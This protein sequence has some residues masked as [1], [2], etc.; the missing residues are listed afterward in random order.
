MLYRAPAPKKRKRGRPRLYGEK[1][2]LRDLAK[3]AAAFTTAQSPIYGESGVEVAYRSLD[4]LWRPVGRMVRFVIVDHPMRGTI[5]LLS[6][7]L[8]MSPLDII[9]LYGYRFK[10]EVGFRQALHVIGAYAY[11][12]WM[13]DMRPIRKNDG[14]QKI[15]N[16]SPQY[17]QAVKRKLGAYHRHVQL[18]CIAQ[19]LLQAP[20]LE[21]F[22]DCVETFP[23]LVTHHEHPQAPI[24]TRRRPRPAYRPLRFS[25]GYAQ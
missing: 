23:K 9:A 25:C 14:N 18:A 17:R 7:D 5:F 10:I 22:Q 13:M 11:H 21:S 4:L 2:K 19:G 1:V 16:K 24:R 15:H 3:D 6:T 12:F 8:L 20:R